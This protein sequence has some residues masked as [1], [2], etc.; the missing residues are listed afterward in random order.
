MLYSNFSASPRYQGKP[1]LFDFLGPHPWIRKLL[2]SVLPE[3]HLGM[4][5]GLFK[6]NY[7]LVVELN[8][9][10]KIIGSYHDPDGSVVP[11]VS[12]VR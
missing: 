7:G 3:R 2:A 6:S 10:G 8:S 5:F 4:I 12:Q 11:D 9:D 1:S